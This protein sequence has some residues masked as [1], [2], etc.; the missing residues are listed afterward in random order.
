MKNRL[1]FQDWDHNWPFENFQIANL[2]NFVGRFN[3]YSSF[4]SEKFS[5]NF[6]I[7][8][9]RNLSNTHV[10]QSSP[11]FIKYLHLS[12]AVYWVLL[13]FKSPSLTRSIWRIENRNSARSEKPREFSFSFNALLEFIFGAR[14]YCFPS[15]QAENRP[16]NVR[17]VG[18]FIKKSNSAPTRHDVYTT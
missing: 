4:V 5:I 16:E 13:I 12:T 7:N 18:I 14:N 15:W 3:R 9:A 17:G 10:L 8:F 11:P 1:I 2:M 6:A